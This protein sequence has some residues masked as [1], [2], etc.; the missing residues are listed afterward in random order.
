MEERRVEGSSVT[1]AELRRS[2]LE[3]RLSSNAIAMAQSRENT[4]V[5][6]AEGGGGLE[7]V[8]S[9][10]GI[11]NTVCRTNSIVGIGLV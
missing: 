11:N 4:H 5:A 2:T 3:R 10:C 8:L 9:L 1:W 6:P 7:L